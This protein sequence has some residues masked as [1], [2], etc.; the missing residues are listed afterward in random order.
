MTLKKERVG[1]MTVILGEK[2]NNREITVVR[3]ETIRIE[4]TATGAAGYRWH[5]KKLDPE[6]LNLTS[7]ESMRTAPEEKMGA[8]MKAIWEIIALK[9]GQTEILMHY[10]RPW[11][12]QNKALSTY[13]IKVNII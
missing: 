5:M 8:A 9:K 3:G 11:E 13:R 12:G 2:D 6:Y 1:N 10:F 4:L 7:E